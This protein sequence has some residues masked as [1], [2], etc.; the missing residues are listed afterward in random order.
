MLSLLQV[1]IVVN[2]VAGQATTL[3]SNPSRQPQ[4]V[5][6]SLYFGHVEEQQDHVRF[7]VLD[8]AVKALIAPANFELQ[9]GDQQTIR[10][11]LRESVP[12]GTTLRSV[13]TFTP[14]FTSEIGTASVSV[15]LV[16]ITR[17]IG[18]VVVVQ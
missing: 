17:I 14:I 11:K 3:I 2:M 16:Q 9:P 15:N 13:V 5:E 4:K 12:I 18:K 8:S 1:A 7:V 10:I 6:V